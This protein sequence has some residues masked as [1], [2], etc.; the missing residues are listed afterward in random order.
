[1]LHD[2]QLLVDDPSCN[3]AGK[4]RGTEPELKLES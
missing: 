3:T 1:M 4:Y 2:M